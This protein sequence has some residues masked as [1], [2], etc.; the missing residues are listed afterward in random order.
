MKKYTKII[1]MIA[2]LSME[3]FRGLY[4]YKYSAPDPASCP[5][6]RKNFPLP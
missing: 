4:L 3:R 1:C 6:C 5:F 2:S